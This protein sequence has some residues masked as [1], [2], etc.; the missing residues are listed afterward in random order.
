MT[1][2]SLEG[3]TT[4][5][6][7]EIR[8]VASLAELE[9]TFDVVGAQIVP[10]FTHVDR[11]F[12]ALARRLPEDRSIMLLASVNGVI[13]GGALAFRE[14]DGTN[15]LLRALAVLPAHRGHGLG[16]QLMERLEGAAAELGVYTLNL[17]AVP[18]AKGFYLR[19][20][21]TG[22]S[23]MH[24]SLAGTGV[25]RYKDTEERQQRLAKL[26]AKAALRRA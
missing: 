2:R 21:Y 23:G 7:Y 14:H 16:Q 9:A 3:V 8:A 24:K 13:V 19:L 22:R 10:P 4:H 1:S 18:E 26:R 6:A 12:D 5:G 15:A 11:R 17:G 25:A 20:G